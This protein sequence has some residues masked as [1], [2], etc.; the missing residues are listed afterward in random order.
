VN[1]NLGD[2]AALPVRA[3]APAAPEEADGTRTGPPPGVFNAYMSHGPAIGSNFRAEDGLPR[4]QCL[5]EDSDWNHRKPAGLV[6]EEVAWLR[7]RLKECATPP[8]P[9]RIVQP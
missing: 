2:E 1:A 7:R 4:L 3:A 8:S 6:G 9:P 5:L